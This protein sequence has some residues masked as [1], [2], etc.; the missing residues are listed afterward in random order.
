MRGLCG[1]KQHPMKS[2]PIDEVL[3]QL[4]DALSHSPAVVLHAP[5]GAG[6]TTRVPPALLDIMTPEKGRIIMLEPRRIAAASA[7]RWMAR[8]LGEEVGETVGYSIRF[9][10]RVSKKTRI[11]VVTEGILTRRIQADPG[12]EGVSLVIFDEFHERSLNADLALA[13]CLDLRSGVRED[14]KVL[15]MSATLDCGPI[16]SLLDG[17]PVISS[18]GKVFPVEERYLADKT[19]PLH[20]RI[21]ATVGTAVSETSGDILIFLPGA[22]EIRA[23][24]EAIEKMPGVR[25]MGI[26]IHHLYGDLPFEEQERAI[27]PSEKRKIVLATNIAETSLT[28]EGVGAVID[29]GLTRRLQYD[30]SNGMNRLITV[31]VSKASA[32]QRKGRAGRLGP[33]VCYRLYSRNAFHAMV[34]FA[35][36]EMLV[37]DLSSLAL[38]LAAWGVKDPSVLSWLDEPPAIS[39]ESAVRLLQDLGALDK[40]ASVTLE[41]RRMCRFPL[42][43]RLA[44]LMLRAEELGC[45]RLGADLAAL[46]SE[47]DILR[48]GFPAGLMLRATEPDITVRADILVQWRKGGGAP[49]NADTWALRSVDRIAGQ[50]VGLMQRTSKGAAQRTAAP[51]EIGRLLLCAFPD[52]VAQV[53]ED[54]DGHFV[55]S[56]GRGVSLPA[57]TALSKSPYI[58]AVNVNA[59]EKAEGIVHLAAPLSEELIRRELSGRIE[60]V[61]R[62]EWDRREERVIATVQERVGAVLLS[63]RPFTPSDEEAL[64]ILCEVISSNPGMLVFSRETRQFQGRVALM[65][66]TFPEEGWLD[67]ER[68]LS[69]PKE[70][71]LP[72]LRGRR[73]GRDIKNMDILPALKALFSWERTRLLEVRAPLTVAVPSGRRVEIDYTVGDVPVLAVKLQEMFGLADTPEIAGGR[74]KVLLHLLSPARRPVQITQDLKGF[75]NSG[76]KQ[77]KKELKGRYPKHPWPDDPWKAIPTRRTTRRYG[78]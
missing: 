18:E 42:H 77:V 30:P 74:V 9:D 8:C 1:R 78:S 34:P 35:P 70:C 2:F 25:L 72:W 15:V 71:L 11:E 58:V 45:L 14:L 46:L 56:K 57:T 55:L 4:K 38:E 39:W 22:G 16:S 29:S 43:P 76:Y 6:K 21:A 65:R 59:G 47:R 48:R 44:R 75:W 10:S 66:R 32:E 67:L 5:P 26:T 36:P 61:R 63:S 64:P 51:D 3:P 41:G 20:E 13:L 7:A 52:R 28:I 24:S 27:L 60:N 23:C 62:V 12:L 40:S 19:R 73:S 69:N 68:F 53:R 54:G 50:L 33:G 31:S 37:S 49:D 17:A